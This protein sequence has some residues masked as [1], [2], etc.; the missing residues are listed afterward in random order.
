MLPPTVGFYADREP[1]VNSNRE[2]TV[3]TS[4]DREDGAAGLLLLT[5]D[6]WLLKTH[7][8]MADR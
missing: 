3:A 8:L 7:S 2:L 5:A 1:T 4:M 6:G